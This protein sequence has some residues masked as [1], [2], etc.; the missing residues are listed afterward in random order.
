MSICKIKCEKMQKLCSCIVEISNNTIPALRK[1][2]TPILQLMTRLWMANI[3]LK[4]GLTKFS[5]ADSAIALFKYEYS[6]PILSPVFAAYSAMTF[7]IACSILLI[8]GLA[9]RVA[10][11][12]LIAMTLVI[13]LFVFQN[14]E[15]FY[16][17]FLFA[18]IL[19]YGSGPISVDYFLI[20]YGKK[21]G[22]LKV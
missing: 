6:V 17:L 16:W 19:I 8:I 4:S 13:Q 9:S 20:K 3:F 2:G 7:E 18:S 22:W 11:L 5:N 15:H 1:Y 10:V 12:P 21:T 14:S